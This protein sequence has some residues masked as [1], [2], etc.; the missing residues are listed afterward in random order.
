MLASF[1]PSHGQPAGSLGFMHASKATPQALPAMD[2]PR[3][4]QRALL[5]ASAVAWTSCALRSRHAQRSKV[6]VARLAVQTVT[7][8]D[9]PVEDQFVNEEAMLA[10]SE[11]AIKPD[12]LVKR[13]KE[14]VAAGVGTKDGAADFADD[15]EFCA[16]VVGPINKKEYLSA[17]RTFK[18][19]DGFPDSNPNYHAFR[20]DPF[21]PDRVWFQTRKT[22]TNSAEFM[23]KPATG[24]ALV[25]PPEAYSLRFNEQG[26]V[27]E[28]TVGYPM[29]RRVGNTG[30]LGGAFGYFYGVGRPI[31]IPEC[32]PYSPSWQ[33]RLLRFISRISKRFQSKKIQD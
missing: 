24:K 5:A 3:K 21:E 9:M 13:C 29:D 30:G 31:P 10:K 23:G 18:I 8:A 2:V 12:D 15:F 20:V 28:F 6:A 19:E 17:L 11:F 22:G 1:V 4:A 25:F 33:F 7:A 26:K 27:K 16:P 14:I 32:K